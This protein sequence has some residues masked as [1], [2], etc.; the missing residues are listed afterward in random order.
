MNAN[1]DIKLIALD[2]DGTLLNE[3]GRLSLSSRR[4]LEKVMEEG[5]HVVISTGRVFSALPEDVL[6]VDGMEY[7][8]TS[9]G[10]NIL[11][12]KD[13]STVYSNLIGE[14]NILEILPHIQDEDI[15]IEAFFDHDVVAERRCLENLQRYGMVTERSQIYTLSTRKPVENIEQVIKEKAG[16]MENINLI[17]S[18]KEKRAAYWRF[19][20]KFPSI[21]VTSSMPYNLEIGGATTSKADALQHLCG[22]LNVQHNQVMACGDSENDLAMLQF[23]GLS[24]AMANAAEPLKKIAHFITKTNREDGVAH[25][26]QRFVIGQDE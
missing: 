4:V 11:K 16:R 7:A 9:N 6:D 20:S 19:F 5:I 10:A 15:M 1:Y 12:L 26:I 21:T 22:L 18:D 24:V 14:D 13:Q 8:I 3:Q 25:A 17:F 23:A 2:M